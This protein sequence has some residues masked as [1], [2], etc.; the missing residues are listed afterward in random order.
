MTKKEEFYQKLRKTLKETTTFPT[1]YLYK[2]IVPSEGE[3][4][5]QIE[6]LFKDNQPKIS[7]KESKKGT[8]TSVT[9]SVLMSSPEAIISKYQQ[10]ES[11][12]G[13]ISL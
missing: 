9:I 6:V 11:I 4:I 8:Y 10:A 5:T 2:F 1:R 13:I 12:K 7:K 3:G